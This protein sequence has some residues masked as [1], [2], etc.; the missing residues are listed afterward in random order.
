MLNKV[1]LGTQDIDRYRLI[2][3][4]GIMDELVSLGK[5]LKGL[6]I[7]HVNSTPFG[8]G[9]AELLVSYIPLLR[10]LGITADWQIIRGNRHFFTI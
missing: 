3:T 2:E 7:C 4:R 5:E 1:S 8:G 10:G 6:R 9:V